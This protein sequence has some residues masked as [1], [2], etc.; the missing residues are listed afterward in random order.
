MRAALLVA[1]LAALA[2]PTWGQTAAAT[3]PVFH[4][5]DED[6]SFHPIEQKSLAGDPVSFHPIEQ[7]SL[8][9]D[10][11]SSGTPVFQMDYTNPNL[12][13]SHW[14]LTLHP[15]GRGHFRSEQG[16]ARTRGIEAPSIDRDIQVSVKFASYVFESARRQRWFNEECDSHLKQLAFEGWKRL[17]YSGPEGKGSCEFNYSKDQKIEDLGASLQAV[18]STIV[19]GARLESLLVHD[20]LGLAAEMEYLVEAAHDGQAQQIC[21]IRD[22]LERLS[23]DDQVMEQVRRRA[24]FLLAQA[25]T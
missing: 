20:R 24:L 16:T 11:V 21:T 22:I 13:P 2:L 25:K 4:P 1:G 6:L 5:N 7:K 18:A 12:S 8:A 14:T 17:S 9:G 10:P 19:E 15:D 3:D 23:K